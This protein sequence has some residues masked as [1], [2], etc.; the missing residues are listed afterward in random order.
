MT[1]E[2]N[3]NSDLKIIDLGSQG[4][5]IE[6]PFHLKEEFRKIF[7]SAKWNYR[8]KRWEVGSRSKTKLHQW[9]ETVLNSGV[10]E[11]F[12]EAEAAELNAK[13][14]ENLEA[15][16]LKVK[17]RY[18][19]RLE[20]C[21]SQLEQLNA[22]SEELDLLRKTNDAVLKSFE[23]VEEKIQKVIFE[24]REKKGLA[25]EQKAMI[26]AKVSDIV[27]ISHIYSLRK[28]LGNLFGVPKARIHEQYNE[29]MKEFDEMISLLASAGITS[30]QL[31]AIS[32]ANYNRPDR[33]G[34]CFT[35]QMTWSVKS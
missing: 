28:K 14:I 27:P 20:E 26:E 22:E 11:A 15:S 35:E 13:E 18:E 29:D 25:D 4:W 3:T 19:D 2:N 16:L 17:K 9:Y 33:D 6:F 34:A 5:A 10:L 31:T 7:K 24:V 12:N 21:N 8:E 32:E 1:N 30:P 23:S